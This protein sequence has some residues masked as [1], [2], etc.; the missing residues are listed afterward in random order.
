MEFLSNKFF[1]HAKPLQKS[2]AA[3]SIELVSRTLDLGNVVDYT[4][5]ES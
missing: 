3:I 5:L 2:L 1:I 4:D